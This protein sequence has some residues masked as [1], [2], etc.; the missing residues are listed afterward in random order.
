MNDW[1]EECRESFTF[2]FQVQASMNQ[3]VASALPPSSLQPASHPAAHEALW[4]FTPFVKILVQGRTFQYYFKVLLLL[5][6]F[7]FF[8]F[9]SCS[10][11][12]LF[13]RCLVFNLVL[14]QR[15]SGQE[16]VIG[17]WTELGDSGQSIDLRRERLTRCWLMRWWCNCNPCVILG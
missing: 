16:G 8:I 6:S 1:Q 11:V 14:F 3:S 7:V 5:R 9:W 2:R 15:L 13:G 4:V 12:K 17:G 10:R